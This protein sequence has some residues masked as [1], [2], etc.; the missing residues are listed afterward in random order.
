MDQIELTQ[1]LDG[2]WTVVMPG[3]VVG[4]LTREVAEA[5]IATY[6]R[7]QADGVLL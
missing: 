6:R 7:L 4:D 1:D 3:L 2:R 5:F